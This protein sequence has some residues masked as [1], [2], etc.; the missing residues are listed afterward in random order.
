M[1]DQRAMPLYSA[2]SFSAPIKECDIV[3]KGGITSGVVYPYAILEL[4]RTYRFRSIGGTSAGAIAAAFAAAAE[5][6]RSVRGD[7]AGFV[8]LQTRCDELPGLL[9]DL[10]Q[11]APRFKSFMAYLLKAQS[12]SGAGRWVWGLPIAF[13]LLSLAGLLAGA[14]L[15]WL[16]GGGIAGAA[17]GALVASTGLIALKVAR[18]VLHHLPA[19]G[20]GLCTGLKQPG[21]TA[22]G[23]TDWLHESIQMIAFGDQAGTADPLT[24]GDLFNGAE[25]DPAIDLRMITTNLSMRRPH[26]LPSLGVSIAFVPDEWRSLFP[27]PVIR[28]LERT[29][30]PFPRLARTR[31]FPKPADL[32]ILVATRMSLS[33]PLLFTAVP[34]YVRDL[35]TYVISRA[36]G[37]PKAQIRKARVWFADGGISS[38]F[39]IHM[40]DA[41]F[42]SRPTFALSLDALP[43]GARGDGERV[44]IPQRAGQG[45]GL[46]V[47]PISGVGGLLGAVMAS[48]KDWQDQLLSTMP[49]QRERVAR[50]FLSKEEGGLNLAMP[51]KRSLALMGYGLTVGKSFAGGA[52]DFDEHRW[53]RSLVVYDQLER[54]VIGTDKVWTAGFG[55][56]LAEYLEHPESYRGVTKTDRRRIH[57]RLAAFVN[58]ATP[59]HP[60]IRNKREKFPRPAGRLRIVP[61]F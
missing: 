22:P 56:W 10:F 49:G 39:P 53:R 8:R 21:R 43:A 6:S 51:E 50:V 11:P 35:A 27:A 44:I 15:M 3:M 60:L 12:G 37:T 9:P 61:N 4:A 33:F 17:L 31:G 42:P 1:S 48:A 54:T 20:F 58:L 14:A 40:F 19:A 2:E 55:E 28:F 45:V 36:T 47:H 41:L 32:P 38:N 57:A 16:L 26:T 24:F 30:R 5:Y 59:F 25:S 29:T 13:P 18:L 23:L 34:A 7:P 52:L 46:S